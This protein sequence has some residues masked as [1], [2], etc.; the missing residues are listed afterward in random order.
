[1]E[2]TGNRAELEAQIIARLRAFDE[3]AL[4]ELDEITQRAEAEAQGG[5]RE[6]PSPPQ[7]LTRRQVLVGLAAGGAVIT[8]ANLAAAIWTTTRSAELVK[9]RGLLALYEG[10]ERV[11]LDAIIAAGIQVLGLALE[12]IEAGSRGLQK[13]LSF[14]DGGLARFEATFPDIRSGLARVEE[15][16]GVLDRQIEGLWAIVAQVTERVGPMAEALGDFFSALLDRIPF[17]VGERIREITARIQELIGGLP[18]AM[19]ALKTHLLEPLR[20]DWFSDDETKGLKGDLIEPLRDRLLSPLN[21][22]LDDLIAF[23]DQWE[24]K[25]VAPVEDALAQ[26]AAIRQQIDEYRRGNGL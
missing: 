23:T 15:L 26:R 17:G 4:R 16:V 11:G 21:A 3:V 9:L 8:T 13:A 20:Q 2:T 14:V 22:L 7:L 5:A 10:L 25:L 1:L 19:D 24:A 18:D 6:S 12:G